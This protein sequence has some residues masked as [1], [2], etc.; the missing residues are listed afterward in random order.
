MSKD[1]YVITKIE[2]QK[3]NKDRVNIYVNDEFAF[4]CSAELVYTHNLSKDKIIEKDTLEEIANEDN[5]IKCKSTSLK[6]IEKSYKTERQ[7]TDKLIEKG[8]DEKVVKRTKEFLKQYDFINDNK[9]AQMYIKDKMNSQGRNKIKYALIN[10]GISEEIINEKLCYI[11]KESEESSALKLAEKKY[12]LL[13]KSEQDIRNI[14]KKLREYLIR[15]GYNLDIVQGVLNQVVKQD[16]DDIYEKE[17]EDKVNEDID[18][19]YELAEKRYKILIKSESDVRKLYKKLGD[20]LLRRGYSWNDI[21][22]A[23][24]NIIKDSYI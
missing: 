3:R 7:I 10:K 6:M 4:A 14:H 19:L 15:K 18:K 21:K 20:Y 1:K 22:A 24:N 11:D 17:A 23:L 9:Y 2:V 13:I 8:Y 12:N 5:Y 16:I